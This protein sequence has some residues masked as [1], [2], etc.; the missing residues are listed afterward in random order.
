MISEVLEGSS[1]AFNV[2]SP[3]QFSGIWQGTAKTINPN[4]IVSSP[5]ETSYKQLANDTNDYV[6]LY[7]PEGVCVN[8]P[9]FV[10]AETEFS[11]AVAWL[12]NPNLLQ[13]GIRHYDSSGFTDFT[14]A[15][16]THS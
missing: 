3:Q 7:F 2:I 15:T 16:L 6:K 14:L 10:E 11:A 5:I 13:F 8:C 12:I 4:W 1:E 9:S